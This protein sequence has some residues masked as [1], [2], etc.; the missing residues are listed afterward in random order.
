MKLT[1][2]YLSA[3]NLFYLLISLDYGPK[4]GVWVVN[5]NELYSAKYGTYEH[6]QN[7]NPFQVLCI[8]DLTL[9]CSR[10]IILNFKA[11]IKLIDK[12]CVWVVKMKNLTQDKLYFICTCDA[13]IKYFLN[14]TIYDSNKLYGCLYLNEETLRCKVK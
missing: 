6:G 12:A 14:G 4:S 5:Q 7:Y 8:Y 3:V 2:N 10:F 13:E 1:H 9:R 11:F